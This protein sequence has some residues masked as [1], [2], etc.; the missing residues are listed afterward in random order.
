V[1]RISLQGWLSGSP[2]R[3]HPLLKREFE[4]LLAAFGGSQDSTCPK[5]IEGAYSDTC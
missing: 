4:L 3:L 5:K 2:V 1:A